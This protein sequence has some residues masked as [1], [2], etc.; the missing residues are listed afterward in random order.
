MK[1]LNTVLSI[2]LGT[3][4]TLVFN[5]TCAAEEQPYFKAP[6]EF[7]GTGCPG[8]N[9]VS[10]SGEN[11]DTMTILFDQFDAAKP[12]DN[13]ASGMMR[14]SC[15][16]AVPVHIPAGFQ[17]STLTADWRGYAER[18]TELHREYFIAAQ[19]E[20][21]LTKTTTFN[22]IDGINYTELDSLEP[23]HYT[24]CQTQARD[25]ILRINS[26]V[27]AEGSDSYIV[28]DTIDKALVFELNWQACNTS[29]IPPILWLLLHPSL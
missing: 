8:F 10:V 12:K 11:T 6:V 1:I 3:A 13:A 24:A 29:A 19:T 17:V 9:S 21:Q 5:Y 27:L 2:V 7:R 15:N 26:R 25:V 16:F 23:G 4:T 14:T 20:S 28:V 22:E 18:E